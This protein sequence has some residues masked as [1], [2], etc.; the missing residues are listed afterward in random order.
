MEDENGFQKAKLL[1]RDPQ[2][3]ELLWNIARP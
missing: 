2:D 3:L 1:T